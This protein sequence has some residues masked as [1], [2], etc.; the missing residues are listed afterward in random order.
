MKKI[1]HS[2]TGLKIFSFTLLLFAASVFLSSFT[3]SRKMTEDFLKQLGIGKTEADAKISS[4]FLGG[5]LDSYGARNAKN[6]ALGNRTAVAKDLLNYSKAY[7]N[8]AAFLKEYNALK[9]GRKPEKY[10]M[11]T[12]EEMQQQMIADA[13]KA[14]ADN[15]ASLK[16]ADP[17]F[18]KIFEDLLV[19]AKKMLKEA[20]DP[21][22]KNLSIYRKNYDSGVKQNEENYKRQ[23]ADWEAEYPTNHLLFIKRRLEAFLDIT[24]DIDYGAE[25]TNKNGFK[26]FVK[27]EYEGKSNQWKMA[28]RAGKEVVEPT[29]EFVKQ[30]ISE[31]K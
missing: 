19:Q 9:E 8:S 23:L 17:H 30:W 10:Q 5:Y 27:K 25:L 26:V 28:F 4:S 18:K 13:K 15:E 22:N 31:I 14:V 2:K 11:K 7:V 16:K 21:N 29:R 20:E 24:K 3:V 12:P 6:I 1:N